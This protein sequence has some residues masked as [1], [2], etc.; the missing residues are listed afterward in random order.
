MWARL[1]KADKAGDMVR[2]L[3]THNTL[4]NL[5]PPIRRSRSTAT[6][7]SPPASAK[8]SCNPTPEKSPSCPPSRRVEQRL[9]ERPEGPR[10]LRSRRRVEGRQTHRMPAALRARRP[11]PDPH[12]GEIPPPSPPRK[13]AVPRPVSKP[14]RTA[15]SLSRRAPGKPILSAEVPHVRGPGVQ[16][17]SV[18]YKIT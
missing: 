7:A 6:S 18:R 8:C 3:L 9:G 2:G 10:R 5:S 11:G 4:P 1:G 17:V 13:R 14:V 15:C 16:P 12:A